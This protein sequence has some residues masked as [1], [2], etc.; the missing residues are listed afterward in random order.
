[1]TYDGGQQQNKIRT[2]SFSVQTNERG[3][4]EAGKETKTGKLL[5]N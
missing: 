3:T 4:Q 5:T 2:E 1:V